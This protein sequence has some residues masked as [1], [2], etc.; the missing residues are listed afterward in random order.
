MICLRLITGLAIIAGI[1]ASFGEPQGAGLANVSELASGRSVVSS[2]TSTVS[3]YDAKS[4]TIALRIDPVAKSISG[5]VT[6]AAIVRSPHLSA[7]SL[8]LADDLTVVSVKS[9]G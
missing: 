7:V 1:F 2:S 3:N 9:E 8:D 6:M 5:S 4:Y